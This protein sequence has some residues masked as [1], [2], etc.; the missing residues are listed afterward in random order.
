MPQEETSKD[1]GVRP[2]LFKGV[3]HN[4][5]RKDKKESCEARGL[6]FG[7]G[8]SVLAICG[9]IHKKVGRKAGGSPISCGLARPCSPV[10]E[11]PIRVAVSHGPGIQPC[12]Y[13]G[14]RVLDA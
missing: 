4:E 3:I 14:N 8:N 9:I 2:K 5:K 12:R 13:S 10:G 1:L 6:G 7:N 11:K